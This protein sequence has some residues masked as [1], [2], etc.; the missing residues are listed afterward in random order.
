MTLF[1]A[2]NSVDFVAYTEIFHN[3]TWQKKAADSGRYALF[4][5]IATQA[6]ATIKTK[7]KANASLA[8]PERIA[9]LTS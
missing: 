8:M 2:A 9:L 4:M 7:T 3:F 1:A 5:E 6:I